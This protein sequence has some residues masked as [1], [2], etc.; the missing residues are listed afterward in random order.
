MTARQP[1]F[2]LSAEEWDSL[3]ATLRDLRNF[4]TARSLLDDRITIFRAF[5]RADDETNAPNATKD[6]LAKIE[7]AAKKLRYELRSLDVREKISLARL[8]APEQSP[9][10]LDNMREFWGD[11]SSLFDG[12]DQ[13]EKTARRAAEA[14]K[15]KKS[16][17]DA[18]NRMWL[19]EQLDK[20]LE[21]FGIKLT[22]QGDAFDLVCT[23]L[24]IADPKVKDGGRTVRAYIDGRGMTDCGKVRP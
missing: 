22:N 24:T 7:A 9:L 13:V 15:P 20:D 3:C 18:G 21:Y 12:L 8:A 14:M 10:L 6:K 11:R 4:P 5:C 23:V 17:V 1:K 19:V 2:L 16:G